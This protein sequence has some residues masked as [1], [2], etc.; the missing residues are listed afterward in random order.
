MLP[1][2]MLIVAFAVG[3][4][5]CSW[6]LAALAD[7]DLSAQLLPNGEP[8]VGVY[9][10]PWYGG[11]PYRHVAWHPEFEYDNQ[12]RPDH[13]REVLRS[14]A[15]HGVN[16]AAYSY[17]GD[18]SLRLFQDHIREAEGLLAE[19]W[20][21]F[22]SPYMEPPTINK[23]FAA[24]DAQQFN[25]DRLAHFLEPTADSPAFCRLGD[26]PFTN[27]YIAYNVPT[28]TDEDL[29][30]FVRGKYG[31]IEKLRAAWSMADDPET[32]R[33]A[34]V[35]NEELPS[36]WEDITLDGL[37]AGTVAFAERQELRAQRLRDGWEA[38]IQG[39]AARTGLQT[40][41]TGDNS[42]TIVSP[43][44]YMDA[45]TGLT[46]YSFGYPL[47]NPT[48]RPKLMSE[49]AKYTG[50]T[51]LYT[52]APGTVGRGFHAPPGV[53]RD[54]TRALQLRVRVGQGPA[55]AA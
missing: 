9:Y 5:G 48:R 20:S 23:E 28:E 43:V 4:L 49:I 45:L 7:A 46:W 8:I 1:T 13:I 24:P 12:T 37:R 27:I 47:T 14:L 26:E 44:A 35:P 53:A 51:F 18:D 17:W 38:V 52:I 11:E 55:N 10:Y 29:R 25:T 33:A 32:L 36:S 54:G 41:Y 42:E 30:T 22:L 3:L 40:R 50:T 21:I 34:A 6:R 39:L 19:G 15:D 2:R 31:T 16:H